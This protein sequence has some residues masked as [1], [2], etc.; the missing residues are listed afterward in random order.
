[1][2][3]G[4]EYAILSLELYVATK[5]NAVAVEFIDTKLQAATKDVIF[6]FRTNHKNSRQPNLQKSLEIFKISTH[7][8]A[9]NFEKKKQEEGEAQITSPERHLEVF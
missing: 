8:T 5:C 9:L 6:V 4:N 1:M 7:F 3:C 2:L